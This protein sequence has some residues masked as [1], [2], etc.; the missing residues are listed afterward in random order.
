M[1]FVFSIS[2]IKELNRKFIYI[3]FSIISLLYSLNLFSQS[4]FKMPTTLKKQTISFKLI[5][6][7]IVFPIKVN[8][9][10]LNFILDSGV[11]ATILFNLNDRDSVHLKNVA[12]IKLR[13]LG[14][15]EPV[16]AILSKGNEFQLKSK[17]GRASCRERV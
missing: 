14:S 4:K 3:I 5:S 13:G 15:E 7:L 9:K 6:N 12:K 10:E 2:K 8:G 16:D 1:L 11:G 17:I